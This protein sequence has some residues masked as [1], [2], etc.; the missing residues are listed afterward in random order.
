MNRLMVVGMLLSALGVATPG[1]SAGPAVEIPIAFSIVNTNT[2]RTAPACTPDGKRYTVRGVLAAPSS[3]L[4]DG[5]NDS[6]TLYLHGSGD[7]STW[8]FT[9]FPG[10]DHIG[11]MA[12]LGHVS[13]FMHMLGYGTSDPADGSA[14]CY[15]SFADIAHQVV[16]HLRAG[17]Y[18]IGD[19]KAL[20]FEH[21]ALIGHSGGALAAELY[22]IS[23]DDIDAVG[24]A[25]WADVVVTYPRLFEGAGRFAVACAGGGRSKTSGGPTGWGRVFNESDLRD[26][27]Y[28]VDDQV[29]D[30]FVARYED[31]PC[32][33]LKDTGP[34][35]AS[36]IVLSPLVVNIPVLVIYGDHDPFAPGSFDIERARYASSN[37]VSLAVLPNSGHNLMHGRTAAAYRAVMSGWLKA[38]GF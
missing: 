16:Q 30:A 29:L 25:G 7:G 18:D 21:V 3:A 12:E 9:G 26:L 2:S 10:V 33:I 32:G 38:R 22:A 23:Y 8:N 28:N 31:D 6:V 35:L 36:S 27:L 20:A 14:I 17:T 13:V 1:R 37:D 24:I 15:G 11:E 5:A 34:L 4:N 19:K